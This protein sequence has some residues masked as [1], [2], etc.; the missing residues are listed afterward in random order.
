PIA[1]HP[2]DPAPAGP[3]AP[4]AGPGAA[5]GGRRGWFHP[6]AG[7]PDLQPQPGPARVRTLDAAGTG[8]P[9]PAGTLEPPGLSLQPALRRMGAPA[10]G[11]RLPGGDASGGA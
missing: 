5:N 10:G 9:R 1:P 3:A 4:A 2:A 6:P 8:H 11:E 7:T